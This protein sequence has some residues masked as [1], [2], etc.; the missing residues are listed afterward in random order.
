[1]PYPS[2]IPSSEPGPDIVPNPGPAEPPQPFPT[3]EPEPTPA[4]DPFPPRQPI[5]EPPPTPEP[6]PETFPDPLRVALG[7]TPVRCSRSWLPSGNGVR[8][9]AG[10]RG[11]SR[12]QTVTPAV[13]AG[14]APQGRAV[15]M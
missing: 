10:A 15:K 8:A 9:L 11:R 5:V 6:G 2:P 4:P 13:F 14:P 3:T 12:Y 7:Y 1:M